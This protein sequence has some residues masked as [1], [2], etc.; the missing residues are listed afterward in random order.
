LKNIQDPRKKTRFVK[1]K[2]VILTQIFSESFLS[3]YQ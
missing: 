1:S 3:S 2:A